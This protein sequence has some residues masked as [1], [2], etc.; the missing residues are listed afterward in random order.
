MMTLKN[1]G[2]VAVASLF[3]MACKNDSKP[4]IKTVEVKKEKKEVLS[5][6]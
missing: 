5:G 6:I 1:I 2:L 4:E 3:I